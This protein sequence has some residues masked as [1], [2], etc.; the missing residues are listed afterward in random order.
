MKHIKVKAI[1]I[2]GRDTFDL[3]ILEQSHRYDGFG[4]HG[5]GVRNEL[6]P[7]YDLYSFVHKEV[8]L[9]SSVVDPVFITYEEKAEEFK[10]WGMS[11]EV[12]LALYLRGGEEWSD[13]KKEVLGIPSQYWPKIKEAVEAY[14]NFFIDKD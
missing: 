3:H 10:L 11:P 2:P 4:V 7:H 9:L 14:N 6:Y 8:A 12:T 1:T 5:H 13:V